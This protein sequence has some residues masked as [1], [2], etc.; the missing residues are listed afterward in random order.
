MIAPLVAG[1]ELGGTKTIVVRAHGH[2]IL[3]RH[4]LPTTDPATTL[5]GARALLDGWHAAAPLAA[6]GI[7]SFGPV[8]LDPAAADHG[9]ILATTKPG[10]TGAPVLAA[11]ADDLGCPAA[12]DTDVNAAALAEAR[13]GAAQGA[14]TMVYLT[15]GTGIGG[16]VV[17]GGRAL[18]G[19]LHPEIGHVLLRRAPDDGFAGH[20]VFH[21]DCAEGL[22]SGPALAARFGEPAERVAADDPRW[23]HPVADLA[24]LLALL[25]NMVSP[26]RIV[27]GGGVG[28]GPPHLVT[29][30]RAAMAAVLGGYHP[31]LDAAAL[32]ALVRPAALGNDA[33]PLGA[34]LLALDTLD[35]RA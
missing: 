27:I 10:W 22:L 4:R 2:E 32:A 26:R 9:R 28:L 29:R 7:A 18:H 24:Q 17:A 35:R 1:V 13:W 12:L 14:D 3:E 16:G 34:V 33:G 19:R 20:C 15:I 5:A 21:R 23:R 6:L 25:V 8:R 31:D 30:A 11:L